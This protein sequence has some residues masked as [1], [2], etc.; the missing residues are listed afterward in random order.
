MSGKLL[1]KEQHA[2][3][4]DQGDALTAED[5]ELMRNRALNGEY[6]KRCPHGEPS[7]YRLKKNDLEKVFKRI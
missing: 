2:I 6:D 1:L 3:P 5:A 7:C 4:Q